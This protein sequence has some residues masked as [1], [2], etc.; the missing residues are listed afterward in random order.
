M[1]AASP[2]VAAAALINWDM[3]P[4]AL[5]A[6]GHAG[7]GA[8]PAGPGRSLLGLGMAA[9]LYPLFL[10]GP[11]LLLCLRSRRMA[12]FFMMLSTFVVS[13]GLVNLPALLAGPGRLAQLLGV[14]LRPHR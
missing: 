8:P 12:D 10:L 2:C 9:K 14:Q 6:L 3:L 7:L 13:W 11:L 4:V 1:L 5:T